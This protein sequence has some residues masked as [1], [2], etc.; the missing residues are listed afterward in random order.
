[1]SGSATLRAHPGVTVAGAFALVVGT[2]QLAKALAWRNVDGA[3]VNQGG[4]IALRPGVR[5]WFAAPVAGAVADG[6]GVLAVALGLVL[7]L[8]RARR[9]AVLVGTALLA[10]G[11]TSNLLDR[12]GLHE[13]TAP[14]SARGV[15]DFIPSGGRSRSNLADLWIALGLLVLLLVLLLGAGAAAGRRVSPGRRPAGRGRTG[16]SRSGPRP[17]PA[18]CRPAA[19]PRPAPGTPAPPA[20]R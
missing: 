19:R 11:W 4:F 17:R 9:P 8:R 3:L 12:L 10:A 16:G 2:D 14:G 6:I 7:V 5:A 18:P 1:M 20:P 13:L 15:V